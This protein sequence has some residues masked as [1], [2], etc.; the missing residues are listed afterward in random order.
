MRVDK[1]KLRLCKTEEADLNYILAAETDDENRQYVIPWS[2]EKHFQAMVN[3]DIAHLIVKNETR[4]G[5]VILAGLLNPNHTIE[6][7]RIVI[8][9]K[10]K[11][12]GKAIV[13]IVKQLAFETYN[14]HRLWLD[15]K[16]QNKL[17]QAVYKKAGFVEE[18]T[19]RECLKVEGRY[20]SLIIMSMLQQE[21]EKNCL[22]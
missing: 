16:V 5:Y 4:I 2:R 21:Y 12:Y 18:G 22:N 6:F 20:D 14:A 17:A 11:G 19:L 1:S 10:A 15:V 3:P 13:E 8:T 7:R 9:E